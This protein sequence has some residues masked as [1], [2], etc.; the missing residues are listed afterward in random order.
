MPMRIIECEHFEPRLYENK[1][2]DDR[3]LQ[4]AQGRRAKGNSRGNNTTNV[5]SGIYE[6]LKQSYG[7]RGNCAMKLLKV[8]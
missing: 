1:S 6:N 3:S 2:S 8:T 4:W 7:I 5:Q